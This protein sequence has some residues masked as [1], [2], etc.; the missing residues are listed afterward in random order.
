VSVRGGGLADGIGKRSV[1]DVGC[2]QVRRRGPTAA[3]PT[4][5]WGSG[6]HESMTTNPGHSRILF[7]A[8][9][10]M[11]QRVDGNTGCRRMM[12]HR[13]SPFMIHG[14]SHKSMILKGRYRLAMRPTRRS[15]A[16]S[17]SKTADPAPMIR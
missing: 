7:M 1:D 4:A 14:S 8:M 5:V 12:T 9:L 13:R 15:P 17:C 10:K 6:P 3:Q 16:D 2:V 11:I